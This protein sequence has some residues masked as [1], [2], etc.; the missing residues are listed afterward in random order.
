MPLTLP[1]TGVPELPVLSSADC[2]ELIQAMAYQSNGTAASALWP[3]SG[4][5][6][7]VPVRITQ[8]RTYQRAWWCNGS[9]VAGNADL[10][11]YTISGTTGTRLQSIGAT[12]Q[13]G[14]SALQQ[15][16]INWTFDPGLYYLA[17]SHSEATTGQYWRAQPNATAGRISGI[18]NVASG[19]S[20]LAASPTVAIYN[21]TYIPLFGL[22]ESAVI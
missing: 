1:P 21:Q 13:A 12:A 15:V 6:V 17:F 7:F 16:T 5:A 3:G 8:R 14:T 4:Y 11:V 22:S 19:Q 18:Y 2:Y 9:A 20:P 10:G